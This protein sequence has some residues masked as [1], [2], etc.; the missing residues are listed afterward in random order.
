MLLK[1]VAL[2]IA[3]PT[4]VQ[5]SVPF[6]DRSM[7]K[8]VSSLAVSVQVRLIWEELAAEAA[9]PVGEGDF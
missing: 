2:T 5:P 7:T 6:E 4:G 1:V 3:L 8:P 9:S